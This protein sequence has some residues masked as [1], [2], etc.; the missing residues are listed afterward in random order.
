MGGRWFVT[1][2]GIALWK[3]DGRENGRKANR[4][5]GRRVP[6]VVVFKQ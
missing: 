1:V 5:R 4:E 6:N 2:C 3:K